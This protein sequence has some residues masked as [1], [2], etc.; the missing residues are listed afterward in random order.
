MQPEALAAPSPKMAIRIIQGLQITIFTDEPL[1]EKAN[2]Q[3]NSR[4][5][6]YLGN[7]GSPYSEQ[8]MINL[9]SQ[10]EEF[11][12]GKESDTRFPKELDHSWYRRIKLTT[13]GNDLAVATQANWSFNY[14]N[15]EFI[16][17]EWL[18]T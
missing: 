9:W 18:E 2:I 3:S 17:P 13:F 14:S 8:I 4:L 10:F 7:F 5:W 12:S 11:K 6:L 1:Q 15:N 16:I